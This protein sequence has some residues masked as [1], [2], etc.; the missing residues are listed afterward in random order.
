[1]AGQK[2][3]LLLRGH[4]EKSRNSDRASRD[5][6][7]LHFTLCRWAEVHHLLWSAG[8]QL[9]R[10]LPPG[11]VE[12]SEARGK[13]EIKVILLLD[14]SRHQGVLIRVLGWAVDERIGRREGK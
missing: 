10:L 7:Y 5:P 12:F 11:E 13:A 4:A 2:P 9:R 6:L 3:V 8:K 14:V 1:M